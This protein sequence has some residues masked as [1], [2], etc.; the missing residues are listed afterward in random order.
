MV[1]ES[2]H[3]DAQRVCDLIVAVNRPAM[4]TLSPAE[5]REAYLAARKALQPDPED[6]AEVLAL[7]AAGPAGPIPL[8]LYRG[9]G[10]AKGT[11]QPAL[12]YYHGGGWVIGDLESHDQA[13]RAIANATRC[14]VVAVDYRLAPEHKFP[15]AV[16]D[17]VAA[18]R[19]VS[20][21]AASLGIDPK[22]IAIGGDSAG[23][24]LAAVAALDARDRGGPPLVLQLLIY[25][26][27]EMSLSF[28]S[29]D[30]HAEQLPLRRTT[31]RWFVNNY[32]RDTKDQADWRAS[33]LRAG[34]FA[35]LAPA[36]VVTAGFDPL[37]DE[38][39]AYAKALADAGVPVTLERFGGQIHG[40][41]NMGRMVADTARLVS[42]AAGA[43][44]RAFRA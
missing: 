8:R 27:T 25:P 24:N 10:A 2:L 18:T 20:D 35:N 11:P 5:A 4:E 44:D 36:L 41:L 3:P 40:F 16:E 33:P 12:V 37:G 38:G 21:N 39:A 32:L 42:L 19:W 23:G 22:R 7:E 34:S 17:A 29:H 14:I 30:R 31:M 15:A 1:D 13:C 9:N 28:P 43:L 26:C 6:V